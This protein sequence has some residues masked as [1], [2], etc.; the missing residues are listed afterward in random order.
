[1]NENTGLNRV[2]PVKYANIVKRYVEQVSDIVQE[3]DAIIFMARKAICFYNALIMQHELFRNKDCCIM[4]SR[5]LEYNVLERFRGKK[6]AII[7]DVVVKGKSINRAI[8]N[9]QRYD[10]H[11]DVYIAACDIEYIR[12]AS[13]YK[14][15]IKMPYVILNR[16]DICEF[17]TYITKYI[18]ISGCPYNIDQPIYKVSF[19]KENEIENFFVENN[20]VDITSKAQRDFGIVSKVTQFNN[21]CLKQYFPKEIDY[22]SV[23]LKIRYIY[24]KGSCEIIVLP[25]ILLPPIKYE[26]LDRLFELIREPQ[27]LKFVEKE[28]LRSEY[29]N[30]L[31]VFQYVYSN[32]FLKKFF[33]D[34][35]I[36]NYKKIRSNEIAQ[37]SLCLLEE[38]ELEKYVTKYF[39][40]CQIPSLEYSGHRDIFLLN[41]YVSKVY[42]LVLLNKRETCFLNSREEYITENVIS[43]PIIR[44]Y[45]SETCEIYEER[46]LSNIID[47]FIDR[48]IFVPTVVHT[49]Q[50]SVLRAYKGGE[51]ASITIREMEMFAL[52]LATYMNSCKK[53]YLDK[54]EYEKLCVL[55]FRAGTRYRIFPDVSKDTFFST[56]QDAYEISY[57]K[58]GARVSGATGKRYAAGEKKLL[59]DDMIEAELLSL[60]SIPDETGRYRDKYVVHERD[61][62]IN[63]FEREAFISSSAASFSA[64]FNCF[65]SC[66]RKRP[67]RMDEIF[68]LVP[69]FNKFLTLISIGDN[70]QERILSL[71]AEIYLFVSIKTEGL[72]LID[73][74]KKLKSKFDGFSSGVWKYRCF[75]Y[76][77]LIPQIFHEMS[78]RNSNVLNSYLE[79]VTRKVDLNT[80]ITY[81]ISEI[82]DYLVSMTYTMYKIAKKLKVSITD[83][84]SDFRYI[85][86]EDNKEILD[87]INKRY[88]SDIKEEDIKRDIIL[89]QMEG[90]SIL[91]RCDIY[92][93]D[94]VLSFYNYKKIFVV[95]SDDGQF[96]DELRQYQTICKESNYRSIHYMI[97]LCKDGINIA[98]QL[99]QIAVYCH[100]KRDIK[101]FFCEMDS[102]IEGIYFS[103]R[104]SAGANFI[105]FIE[106]LIQKENV[107]HIAPGF[108]FIHC[109][110]KDYTKQF[111][112]EKFKLYNRNVVEEYCGYTLESYWL[113]AEEPKK[114]VNR[115]E[116]N[117]MNING[118]PE[119][120]EIHGDNYEIN[121]GSKDIPQIIDDLNLLKKRVASEDQKI[122]DETIVAIQNSDNNK[123][124]KYL[125][126]I[127]SLGKDV[128]KD[129]ASSA[130]LAYMRSLGIIP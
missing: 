115:V 82:G 16:D 19:S 102:E 113:E 83:D 77:K 34:L 126:S 32:I 80:D 68:Y 27:L 9:L 105:R 64:L 57:A 70:D 52:S 79:Y 35:G 71:A 124:K 38:K 75:K 121:I 81:F 62:E 84:L 125:T 123:I 49:E 122:I 85:Y 23:F 88:D 11:P 8:S 31:N 29:E 128:L 51:I 36:N 2:F 37:F 56:D 12:S 67:P 53:E 119:F 118:N 45:I 101:I 15:Y 106:K 103:K 97:I 120:K 21:S 58:F 117:T 100:K 18:E 30:K 86:C 48:G 17:A 91:D 39:S 93:T 10:I 104:V 72:D 96:P 26:I 5:A 130:L 63:D 87:L 92:T 98:K 78:K 7:D 110:K 42:D 43:V 44:N 89:L 127:A 22:S 50:N 65:Q 47:I 1:M 111:D 90:R 116:I 4:S 99:E 114:E 95:F 109:Y 24:I 112:M 61:G 20:C 40:T 55:F 94:E 59:V 66:L 107:I 33:N 3:Y 74:I 129:A 46:T 76:N 69:T 73:I 28:N 13:Q 14:D 60:K 6:F 41:Q 108:E 54:I 25:F